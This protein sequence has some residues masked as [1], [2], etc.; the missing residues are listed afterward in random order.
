MS[1]QLMEGGGGGQTKTFTSTPN[2]SNV[3]Q[4]VGIRSGPV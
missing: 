1:I 4:R 3:R 2:K